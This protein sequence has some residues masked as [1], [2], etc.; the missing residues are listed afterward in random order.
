MIVVA[1]LVTALFG[2]GAVAMTGGVLYMLDRSS[3]TSLPVAITSISRVG[4]A[5]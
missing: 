4:G 2:G 5:L 3:R 1:V